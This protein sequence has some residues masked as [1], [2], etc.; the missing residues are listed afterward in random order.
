MDV[1]SCDECRHHGA[2][3][4][5]Y[6]A[7]RTASMCGRPHR[8]AARPG[9]ACVMP[10]RPA[11]MPDR[12]MSPTVI[13][14]VLSDVLRAVR[15]TGAVYFDFN[16]SAPWVA[17]AP[18][19]REIAGD[20]DAGRAARHRI[21]PRG[22]RAPR[23]ATRSVRR[24]SGSAKAICSSSRKAMRTCC[25]ARRV[26]ARHPI[27]RS[28]RGHRRRCRWCTNLA[29]AAP[30]RTRIVCGFLGCDER[31]F[32]PLLAALPRSSICRRRCRS[33][34]GAARDVARLSPCAS[35]AVAIP[36]RE[37]CWRGCPS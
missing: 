12:P 19:S 27:W 28:T 21:P 31:P 8:V 18:P 23:G 35:R 24:R 3:D 29:P 9:T 1:V 5:G 25:R 11:G 6:V 32:N 16:L 17:E 14:D 26:C 36:A 2:H 15:L 34:H 20:R 33:G 4:K 30:D 7:V 10:T 13:A 22:A 37:K